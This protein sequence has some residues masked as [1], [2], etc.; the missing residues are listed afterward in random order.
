MIATPKGP[1]M[2]AME[3]HL[4]SAE[5]RLGVQ[6]GCWDV[7]AGYPDTWPKV[8]FWVAAAARPNAPTRFFF[9]FDCRLYPTNA[10][11]GSLCTPDG[12]SC[13][14]PNARPKG[15]GRVERV[16]RWDWEGGK[17]LY[18]PFD[19]TALKGHGTWANKHRDLIWTRNSTI[20]DLLS[21][22]H[23][24]LNCGEYRGV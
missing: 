24:L 20:V 22:L 3:E 12:S 18:H 14:P 15:T 13:L 10:V 23:Q 9:S 11:T 21:E 5:F 19:R 6:D 4:T 2:A 1:D 7:L 8:R 17:A 16:F